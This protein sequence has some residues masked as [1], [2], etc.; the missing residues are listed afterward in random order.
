M[1]QPRTRK[2]RSHKQEQSPS[3]QDLLLPIMTFLRKSG[4]SQSQ[5]HTEC[6]SAIRQAGASKSQL[7]VVRIGFGYVSSSIVNRWLRDPSFLNHAGQP[8]DL[9]VRGVRSIGSLLKAC[10]VTLAPAKVVALLVEFGTIKMVSSGRYRLVRRCLNFMI[11]EYL[12]FEPNFRFLVD[13]ALASTRRLGVAHNLPKL[14]WQ[15]ADSKGIH[16]RHIPDFLR[17]AQERSLSFMHEVNDWL[18]EHEVRD[19]DGARKDMD[20]RRLGVGLFGICSDAK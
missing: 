3:T 18:E 10:Q 6:R 11:P 8:D 9:P 17:F 20:V 4:I 14:F 19:T 2:L 5:L 7:K 12:P 15:C 1:Y 16:R 13:A